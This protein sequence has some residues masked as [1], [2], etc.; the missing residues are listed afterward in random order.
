MRF[1]I[2]VYFFLLFAAKKQNPFA[3]D[4]KFLKSQPL[5]SPFFVLPEIAKAGRKA[6]CFFHFDGR[7]WLPLFSA[8]V[9]LF[10]P[11]IFPAS[12]PFSHQGKFSPASVALSANFAIIKLGK[13]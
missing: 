3:F 8:N 10:S 9:H 2:A 4:S 1:I 12:T 7:R 13:F 11:M 5:S 6:L